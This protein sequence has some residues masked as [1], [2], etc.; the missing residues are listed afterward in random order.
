MLGEVI[1]RLL[2][3]YFEPAVLRGS[4]ASAQAAGLATT[5][6]SEVATPGPEQPWLIEGDLAHC[7]RSL[8]HQ[9][10]LGTVDDRI[11]DAQVPGP[12][13]QHAESRI[14]RGLAVERHL[15]P[16]LSQGGVAFLRIASRRGS[17]TTLTEYGPLS[18]N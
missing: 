7:F 13:P 9:M 4:Y 12:A 15:E 18:A 5:A 10:L 16:A 2:E 8:D 11:H 3:A 6:W 14:P 1:R 17:I